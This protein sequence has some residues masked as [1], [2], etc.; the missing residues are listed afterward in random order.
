M[1][2]G[3]PKTLDAA[4]TLALLRALIFVEK[5]AAVHGASAHVNS[6]DYVLV[7]VREFSPPNVY[8]SFLYAHE[9]VPRI[10]CQTRTFRFNATTRNLDE[11]LESYP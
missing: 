9:V 10:G 5:S 8:V 6:G 2:E 1:M 4:R 7:V 3:G 11:V